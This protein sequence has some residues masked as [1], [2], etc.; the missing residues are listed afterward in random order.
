MDK[1]RRQILNLGVEKDI[2]LQPKDDIKLFSAKK[3]P[4]PKGLFFIF[5]VSLMLENN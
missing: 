4:N 1:A 2:V 3:R 5:Y